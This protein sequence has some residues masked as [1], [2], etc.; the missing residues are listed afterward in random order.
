MFEITLKA[1]TLWEMR[2][3]VADFLQGKA[4]ATQPVTGRGV[5]ALIPANDAPAPRGQM[6][7]LLAQ[8][9]M[10]GSEGGQQILGNEGS[11]GVDDVASN[12]TKRTRRTKAQIAADEAAEKA[13][14]AANAPRNELPEDGCPNDNNAADIAAQADADFD[15]LGGPTEETKTVDT[16]RVITKDDMMTAARAVMD[17]PKGG[18]N[19]LAKLLADHGFKQVTAVPEG[20]YAKVMADM[21][22]I[23]G[24]GL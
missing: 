1:A 4:P 22:K 7:A 3:M 23:V 13:L 17:A 16:Q 11:L 15:L 9:G 12:T 2:E 20:S 21:E 24:G 8:V 14:L 6:D 10:L 18:F 5:A 19:A